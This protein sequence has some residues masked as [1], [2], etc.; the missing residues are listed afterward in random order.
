MRAESVLRFEPKTL[1]DFFGTGQR[2]LMG[3]QL[4]DVKAR[5]ETHRINLRRHPMVEIDAAR[6]IAKEVFRLKKRA[7]VE[8]FPHDRLT[9]TF[10]SVARFVDC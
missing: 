7:E 5:V 3:R 6:Q 8:L 2:D 9:L 1:G 10:K 4:S